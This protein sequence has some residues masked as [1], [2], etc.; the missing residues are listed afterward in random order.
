MKFS[1]LKLCWKKICVKNG[2][3]PRFLI[4]LLILKGSFSGIQTESGKGPIKKERY[5]ETLEIFKLQS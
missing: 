5:E 2:E 3:I 1:M 4:T